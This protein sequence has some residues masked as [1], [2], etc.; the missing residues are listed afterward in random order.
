MGPVWCVHTDH[1]AGHSSTLYRLFEAF[2]TEFGRSN[3]KPIN[4]RCPRA[5]Y[6]IHFSTFHCFGPFHLLLCAFHV[7][8]IFIDRNYSVIGVKHSSITMWVACILAYVCCILTFD[9]IQLLLRR[10][11][12]TWSTWWWDV[13]PKAYMME[14]KIPTKYQRFS[15]LAALLFLFFVSPKRTE[16]K[17]EWTDWTWCIKTLQF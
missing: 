3:G 17:I 16:N 9:F 8:T 14:H 5:I 10:D 4:G 13:W 7:K 2:S 1:L 15:V 12:S 11:Q 6:G